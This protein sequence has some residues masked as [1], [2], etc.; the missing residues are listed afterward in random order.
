[1]IA[2]SVVGT[3][4]AI[5]E[6]EEVS[7]AR[8]RL[9]CLAFVLATAMLAA[10][11]ATTVNQIMADPS[12]Y[13]QREVTLSGRVVDSMSL[14]DRG[15]YRLEDRTGT[16]WVISDHG[17]PRTGARVTVKGTIR[18]TFNFDVFGGRISLPG[19]VS[20]GMVLMERV[21]RATY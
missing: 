16:L 1:M 4:F 17:V 19:G 5:T 2:G 11:C 9:L 21:H 7:M 12:R 6:A 10:D 14:G 8:S 15:A 13:R 3:R 20:S 18:D